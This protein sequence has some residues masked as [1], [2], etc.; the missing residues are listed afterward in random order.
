MCTLQALTPLLP[1]SDPALLALQRATS[2]GFYAL[3]PAEARVVSPA[4]AA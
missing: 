1:K 4:C 2:D 3:T